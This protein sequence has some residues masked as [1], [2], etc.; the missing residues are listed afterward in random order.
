M[1]TIYYF[2][3]RSRYEG[4]IQNDSFWF[5]VNVESALLYQQR[6]DEIK[7]TLIFILKMDKR[8]YFRLKD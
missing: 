6:K 3:K 2:G 5:V 7:K 4:N 1:V 8:F